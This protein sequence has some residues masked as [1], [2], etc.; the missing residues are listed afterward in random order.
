[1]RQK[2]DCKNMAKLL[3]VDDDKSVLLSLQTVLVSKGFEVIVAMNGHEALLEFR[4]GRADLV[5][6]DLN[7]PVKDGWDTFDRL[8]GIDPLI[9][10]I[11]ITARADQFPRASA[12]GIAALMEKPIE[13]PLL[14]ATIAD[15]LK[16]PTDIRLSR[17]T[18]KAPMT[19]YPNDEYP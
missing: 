12:A 14:L 2:S 11:L 9:P 1:M 5:L 4:K 10:V 3:L 15:V 7:M 8:K 16:Q 18:G 13:I 17:I 19:C 6:L